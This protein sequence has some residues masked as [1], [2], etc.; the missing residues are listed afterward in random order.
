MSA[1]SLDELIA[2]LG[3]LDD[4]AVGTHPDVLDRLHRALVD[5]LD[6]L[7]ALRSTGA[8]EAASPQRPLG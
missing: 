1:E 2:R 6:T 4:A 7:T 3:E 8:G 5:E